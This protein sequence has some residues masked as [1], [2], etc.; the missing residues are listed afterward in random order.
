[1]TRTLTLALVLALGSPAFAGP[2]Q[3]E[4]KKHVEKATKLHADGK[5]DEALVELKAA[6]K[7]DPKP[8]LLF[9]MGQVYSKLGDCKQADSHF[10]QY[11][12]KHKRDKQV[13]HIVEEAIHACKPVEA[14]PPPPPPPPEP[15]PPAAV[16]TTPP[17]PPAEPAPPPAPPPPAP[18]P[19]APLPPAPPPVE[20]TPPPAPP[21]P[22]A[23]ASHRPWY[24][25][26]LGDALV[27]AGVGASVA[28]L[29]EYRAALSDLDSAEKARSIGDYNSLVDSAH[30]AR[31][32]SVVLFA[33]G[34]VLVGGG[35][36]HYVLAGG[37][38]EHAVAAVPTR[39][40]ALVTWSGGF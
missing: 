24:K 14:A 25:D 33:A 26:K 1:M 35:V 23:H 3:V 39:G 5:F 29:F 7:L 32:I 6:Y 9:A 4:A 31:N 28:G 21:A 17:P 19:P 20:T 18:P 2:R 15:P 38:E 8:D 27:V 10:K 36:A 40:G 12:A 22:V 34:A 30:S 16:E 13:Q 37:G 11:G